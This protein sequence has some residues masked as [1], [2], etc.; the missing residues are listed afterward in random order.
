[1]VAVALVVVVAV[2][3]VV[4]VVVVV[5]VQWWVLQ[6]VYE[7]GLHEGDHGRFERR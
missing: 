6:P 1:M 5:A 3:L 4:V 7:V 2:A